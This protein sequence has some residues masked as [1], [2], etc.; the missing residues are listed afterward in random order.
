MILHYRYFIV[1][2][3]NNKA[4]INDY[5]LKKLY[6]ILF[7]YLYIKHICF[8]LISIIIITQIFKNIGSFKIY[9]F[10]KILGGI[11]GSKVTNKLKFWY[12]LPQF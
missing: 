6:L 10:N 5:L 12:F 11:K 9:L 2:K 8:K 4:W 7:I 1:S 3:N